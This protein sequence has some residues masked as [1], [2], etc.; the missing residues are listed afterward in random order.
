MDYGLQT[1]NVVVEVEAYIEGKRLYQRIKKGKQNSSS[2]V[3]VDCFFLQSFFLL[4]Y[5]FRYF[6]CLYNLI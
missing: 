4:F 2:L 6:H 3:C 1:I 5:F